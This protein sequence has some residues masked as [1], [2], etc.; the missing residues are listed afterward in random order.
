MLPLNKGGD[1]KGIYPVIRKNR[2]QLFL[3]LYLGNR[4]RLSI[5]RVTLQ[6]D[7]NIGL[8]IQP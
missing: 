4:Y 8:Q 7:Y 3:I 2:K 6:D 5:K 1:L